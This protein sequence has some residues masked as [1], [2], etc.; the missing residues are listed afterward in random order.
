VPAK[1]N[2]IGAAGPGAASRPTIETHE[3]FDQ[4]FLKRFPPTVD[5]HIRVHQFTLM[6][7]NLIQ[8]LRFHDSY[9]PNY[10][11]TGTSSPGANALYVLGDDIT[12]TDNVFEATY[13]AVEAW[14]HRLPES[15]LGKGLHG[16]DLIG[17]RN[18][19]VTGNTFAIYGHSGAVGFAVL[20]DS[21]ISRNTFLAGAYPH[22]VAL[23]T[24]GGRHVDISANT[25][26]GIDQTHSGHLIGWRAG[27]FLNHTASHENILV[28]GNR[29]S[30]IG[31]R[32]GIDADHKSD[33]EA[34]STDA[35]REQSR[36]Q[37]REVGDVRRP[38][39]GHHRG[40]PAR[41]AAVAQA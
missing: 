37:V 36:F 35:P 5:S 27:I 23:G 29:F 6:G 38:Q 16:E 1:V 18:V 34:I 41:H 10:P 11:D 4:P 30:C 21:V 24:H 31:S 9:R 40:G 15:S 22:T 20:E 25:V 39:H 28:A 26:N 12:I 2:L 3:K 14:W 13:S 8:G 17:N 19:V 33:G 32:S 7:S